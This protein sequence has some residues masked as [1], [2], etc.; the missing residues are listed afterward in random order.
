MQGCMTPG[1]AMTP[2][3]S[4]AVL[5]LWVIIMQIYC[6]MFFFCWFKKNYINKG[7]RGLFKLYMVPGTGR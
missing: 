3:V 4:E 7:V 2:D 6:G 1:S 5:T